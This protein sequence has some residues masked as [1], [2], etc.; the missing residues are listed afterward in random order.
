MPTPS[1]GRSVC[2]SRVAISWATSRTAA[3]PVRPRRGTV[4]RRSRPCDP[5]HLLYKASKLSCRQGAPGPRL[6]GP[7]GAITRPE[8]APRSLVLRRT[9][10]AATRSMT[11]AEPAIRTATQPSSRDTESVISQLAAYLTDLTERGGATHPGRFP[12][13]RRSGRYALLSS[14]V[15]RRRGSFSTARHRPSCRGSGR[16]ICT[17]RTPGTR[18]DSGHRGLLRRQDLAVHRDLGAV[19]VEGQEAGDL[20][21]G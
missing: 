2:A 1:T 5:Y 9:E 17:P 13:V 11:H 10:R 6:R 4:P 7:V 3:S 8:R 15:A 14:H 20:G 21:N 12:L 19:R 16:A 18:A